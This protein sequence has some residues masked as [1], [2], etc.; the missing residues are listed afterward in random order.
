MSENG[1]YESF[2]YKLINSKSFSLFVRILFKVK[3]SLNFPSLHTARHL[4]S[5]TINTWRPLVPV[6]VAHHYA[7]VLK[8]QNLFLNP[9]K[10]GKYL[11][12]FNMKYVIHSID[13]LIVSKFTNKSGRISKSYKFIR[14]NKRKY[15]LIIE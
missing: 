9:R 15:Q 4:C 5:H 6:I 2:Y 11:T 8:I 3:H 12:Q 10:L 14:I 7:T 1:L 13:C